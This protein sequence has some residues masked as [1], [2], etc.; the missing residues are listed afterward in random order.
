M[1]QNTTPHE[2][3]K[4]STYRKIV[5]W[6][7]IL[8]IAGVLCIAGL[9]TILSFQDLPTFEELE[10]PKNN[11]ASEVYAVNG[12]VLGRYYVENRVPVK[13]NELS[14]NMVK[15]L[16]ATEDERYEDHSGIDFAGLG[17]V[18]VKTIFLRQKSAGGA[19]TITQQLSKLL[20]TKKPGSGIE[21]VFQ[22]FKEW[23][24]AVKL[25]K[26]Y[27]KQEI[28][29][30]YLNKFN[31]INGAYGIRAA[32]EIYFGKP[33]DQLEIQESATLV[34]MLKNPSLYNPIRRP[35]ITKK[36]REVVMK[37]MVK[38]DLMTQASY[39]SLR[40]LPLDMSNFKRETHNDGLAPYF[41]MELRKEVNK[42]LASEDIRKADGSKYNIFQDGLRVFTTLD[43]QMQAHAEQAM[44]E[45]MSQLQKKF[46]RVWKNKDPWDYEDSEKE[47]EENEIFI[48]A[49]KAGLVKDVRETPRYQK[50]RK[51]HFE[52]IVR[53][54]SKDIDGFLIRDVDVDRML[55]E[56]KEKG[57]IKDLEKRKYVGKKL[58]NHYRKVMKGKKWDDLQTRWEK[59]Q[60][61]VKVT[62]DKPVPM[63]VFA[64]NDQMEKR[65]TMSPLDSIRYHRMFLQLGSV[66]VDPVTGH[67]KTW[68]GGINH[69][70]FKYDHA[71]S[72][73]QVG[74]TFKPFVYATAIAEQGISPCFKVYDLPVTIHAGEGTFHLKE[75]WT[76]NNA[77]GEYSG[78]PYTLFR[79][80]MHSKN[81]VSTFLMKQLGDVAPVRNLVNN[82]GLDANHQRSNG[83]WKVPHGPSICLGSADLTALE[84]TGAYTTF[85]NNGVHNKPYFIL[86]IEDKNRRVIYRGEPEERTALNPNSNY[87]MLQ[88]LKAVMGQGIAGFGGVTSELGGKTGTTNDYV[89]GWFVGLSPDLVVGTWVGGDQRW[90]RFLSLANGIGAKMARPFYAN[91]LKKLE[92][93]E[94]V[95]YDKEARFII[96][97][98]DIGIV[99]DC[100]IYEDPRMDDQ[101]ESFFGDEEDESFGGDLF[102]DESP[103]SPRDTTDDEE[104][105]F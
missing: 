46:N 48:A 70:Y 16:I 104:E 85:A 18:L 86:K 23:I 56:V 47:P 87:V 99:L 27:T 61:L 62:F 41:R 10:N 95:D 76:P 79:G 58:A 26:S 11:L 43:P 32:S 59:F 28:M 68:V 34:G 2:K 38:N 29:A 98:G 50:M 91:F 40:M 64:Y 15:A 6:F 75:D 60:K 73:R 4:N 72:E 67:V 103:S 78:D 7:W 37:Q 53:E 17:R 81:T 36:R 49:S 5:R 71:T 19:S 82:M 13:F 55:S 96:P 92:A 22:K 44:I 1:D 100:E 39:D 35:E 80:L 45:H 74:S 105:D 25:E 77:N 33:Q 52:P 31:F 94:T 88:M 30:M 20:F 102:G 3:D 14:S 90:I 101:R 42:I 54:I 9:F 93:D 24:I 97:A 12:D 84:L 8:S 57:Y 89:D 65:D 63:M 66:G 51:K 69:K 21:R 83:S